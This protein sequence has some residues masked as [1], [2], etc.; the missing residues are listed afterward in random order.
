MRELPPLR[1]YR[2]RR[3]RELGFPPRA[4]EALADAMWP[5]L[6]T[7]RGGIERLWPVP[8]Y[9]RRVKDALD[10][11]CSHMQALAIFT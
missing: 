6:V 10:G 1:E 11:G 3:F 2:A 4:S 7:C 5:E 8:L 9:W